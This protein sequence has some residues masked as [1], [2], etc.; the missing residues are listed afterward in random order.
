MT[1]TGNTAN[2]TASGIS[3]SI[4]ITFQWLFDGQNLTNGGNISGA[5]SSTLTI[6]DTT[7]TNVGAYQLLLTNPAGTTPSSN[8]SPAKPPTRYA[9]VRCRYA[10]CESLIRCVIVVPSSTAASGLT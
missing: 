8:A 6:A 9:A 5:Q 2:L 7:T 3:G 10:V 4:P 1:Y